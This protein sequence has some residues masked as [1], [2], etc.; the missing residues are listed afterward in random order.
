MKILVLSFFPAFDPPKSGGE[1]R[2]LSFYRALSQHHN[3]MLLSSGH[4]GVAEER[5]QHAPNFVERRIS[6]DNHFADMWQRLQPIAGAGDLS[7]PCLAA[8]S[9]KL[10]MLH[11]AYLEE[12]ES[13][14]IIVHD[15]PFTI[16]YDLLRHLDHKPRVYNSYNCESDL[17]RMMHRDAISDEI[18]KIVEAAEDETL[19]AS[20]LVTYCLD[21]DLQSFRANSTQPI[22][23]TLYVPNGLEVPSTPP[24]RLVKRLERVLFLGSGHLPNRHAADFIIQ[25]IAPHCPKIV[26]DIVGSCLPDGNYPTNVVRHGVVDATTKQE[27]FAVADLAINPMLDGSGSSLKILDFVSQRLP[28]LSTP[29]GLRGFEFASGVHCMT[30]QSNDFANALNNLVQSSEALANLNQLADA[31]YELAASTYTWP[32]IAHNFSAV[33]DELLTSHA[34]ESQGYVLALNDYDPYESIGGGATRIRGIYQSVA[35]KTRVVLLCFSSDHTFDVNR[36]AENVWRVR[37]PKTEAHLRREA[38]FNARF[39]VSAADIL[40]LEFCVQNTLLVEVYGLIRRYASAVVCDHPY[41][42]PLVR[43]FDD[44]FVYS[45]QNHETSLKKDLLQWHP[46][47]EYLMKLVSEWEEFCVISAAATI[48]VSEE[49]AAAMLVGA[50][51]AGPI[52]VVPNG[53][54]MP[55]AGRVDALDLPRDQKAAVFVGSAH[56]PNVD[57]ATFIVN[58]LAPAFPDVTFHIIGSVCHAF[59]NVSAPNVRCWGVLDDAKKSEVMRGSVFA[60]NPMFS[61]GGSNIKLADYLAHGLRV[62]STPFGIRGYP[63]D[64]RNFVTVAEP[65]LF[66]TTFKR[67]L[68]NDTAKD[69]SAVKAEAFFLHSLSMV[70]LA[71]PFRELLLALNRPRRRM[72]FVTYR[73]STPLRGGAEMYMMRLLSAVA[74][75]GAFDIDVV[76]PEVSAVEDMQRF[77]ASYAFDPLT[78]TPLRA[79][80]SR[81]ARFPLSEAPSDQWQ[82]LRKAWLAQCEFEKHL[83]RLAR[84]T[85]IKV[86]AYPA[87]GWGH[88]EGASGSCARWMFVDAGVHAPCSGH[89]VLAGVAPVETTLIIQDGAHRTLRSESLRGEFSLRFEVPAGDVAFVAKLTAP[90][91]EED[92]R[93][94]ALYITACVQ[95]RRCAVRSNS[96]A[97]QS[98]ARQRRPVQPNACGVRGNP[99]KNGSIA[100]CPARTAF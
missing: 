62:V 98:I 77:C 11:K 16:G 66:L 42:S 68:S 78:S 60:L 43:L 33:L 74:A 18:L 25:H 29:V 20:D 38:E 67:C 5:I 4:V 39:H 81:F 97:R 46:D 41:M 86:P 75:S 93:P 1:V 53:A 89:V 2:L 80:H 12:Y 8:S 69:H 21:A 50:R 30:A 57:S 92:A 24:R 51:A 13:A 55:I 10:T 73:F 7:A 37:I 32:R 34:R 94:L 40:C 23:R 70:A 88:V 65:E 96:A 54:A 90:V 72:L 28:V 83:Y 45:S 52:M 36:V 59:S 48:A 85:D 15:S 99:S 79:M 9:T 100:H 76:A 95:Q 31:A 91:S 14:D 58:E 17:Y 26:F 47:R 19:G 35:E 63:E 3:I 82:T 44:R 87:W 84:Q 22:E 64:V 49:D 6:K 27:L 61:G 71:A 56:M